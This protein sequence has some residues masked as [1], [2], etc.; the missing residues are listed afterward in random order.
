M[1]II[2]SALRKTFLNKAE[3]LETH[4]VFASHYYYD[5][6]LKSFILRGMKKYKIK[7]VM[8]TLIDLWRTDLI[9]KEVMVNLC[10]GNDS[11]RQDSINDDLESLLE[12]LR[13]GNPPKKLV[14]FYF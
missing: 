9:R 11:S 8:V 4:F 12:D 3:N 7:S 2:D 6:K 1:E 5:H 10:N 14:D 13:L